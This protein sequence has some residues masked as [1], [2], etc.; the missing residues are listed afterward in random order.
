M[1]RFLPTVLLVLIVALAIGV[2]SLAAFGPG[3]P[4]PPVS[5][6]EQAPGGAGIAQQVE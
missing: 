5:D 2:G 4:A 3:A 6:L 1:K